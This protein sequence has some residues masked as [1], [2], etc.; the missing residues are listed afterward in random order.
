L[1]PENSFSCSGVIIH[2]IQLKYYF[3]LLYCD[4][5]V[6]PL[7]DETDQY[8]TKKNDPL[9]ILTPNSVGMK[10]GPTRL[11][12]AQNRSSNSLSKFGIPVRILQNS[13]FH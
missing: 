13:E 8:H 3:L 6:M 2:K 9:L 4:T 1:P 11:V 5:Y 12:A 10:N 7:N